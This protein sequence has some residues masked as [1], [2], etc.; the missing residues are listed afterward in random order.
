VTLLEDVLL[1]AF[2]G[3]TLSAGWHWYRHRSRP[4]ILLTGAFGIIGF[5]L[6]AGRLD[7]AGTDRPGVVV[8]ITT[9]V[10]LAVFPWLLAAFAW[11]FED[12]SPS[13]LPP[14]GI[15]VAALA[16]WGALL[17]PFPAPAD[18]SLTEQLYVVVFVLV[19]TLLS[20][21]AAVR[22]WTVGGRQQLVRARMRLMASGMVLLTVALFVAAAGAG[23]EEADTVR[24][25]SRLLILSSAALFVAGFAPPAPLRLWWRR[26]A[27]RRFQHMQ[28]ALIGAA[29]PHDVATAVVPMLADMLGSGV[30]LL[31]ADGQVLATVQIPEDEVVAIARRR[32]SDHPDD[33]PTIVVPVDSS[34]LMIRTSPYTPVFGQDERE[35]VTAFSLQIRMA[36]ERAELFEEN[37]QARAEAERASKELEAMLYGLS[38]DLRS[39]AIAISGFASLLAEMEDPQVRNEMIERIQASTDYLND[40]VDA[41]LE[42]AKIGRTQEDAEPVELSHIAKQVGRRLEANHPSVTVAVEEPLPVVFLNP[43]RAEQLLDNLVGNAVKHGGREDLTVTISSRETLEGVELVVADDGRGVRP[44]D[45]EVIFALFQR[46]VDA[47]GR[48]SGL[49][50]G[51]VRRI[52]ETMG[53]SVH[54]APSEQGATFVVALPADIVV[55]PRRGPARGGPAR[56]EPSRNGPS[57]TTDPATGGT[58]VPRP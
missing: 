37:L 10:L 39:P 23:T 45:R 48:G 27:T 22:L 12:R 40:L 11:S 30:A 47:G 17:S 15:L 38:H 13:W 3:L 34:L 20:V 53:G 50:L 43:R 56:S 6:L 42:L 2:L 36:L 25:V 33:D 49:G 51:T 35:L 44:E 7:L 21:A 4:A 19:W 57:G 18:R 1:I 26:R 55:T 8:S 31:G 24:L 16:V 32:S 58:R 54:L 52:V 14:A 29:T 41:L 5:V 46:G 9:V 28:L